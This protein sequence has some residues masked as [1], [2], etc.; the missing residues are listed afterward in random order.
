VVFDG[1]CWQ[2]NGSRKALQVLSRPTGLCK[3]MLIYI[4]FTTRVNLVAARRLCGA[5]YSV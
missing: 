4:G 3:R 5:A 1:A 2:S